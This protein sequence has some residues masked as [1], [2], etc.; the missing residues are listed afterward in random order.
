LIMKVRGVP[1]ELRRFR[2]LNARMNLSESDKSNFIYAE[3]GFEGELR[4]DKLIS[5]LVKDWVVLNDVLFEHNNTVFQIDSLFVSPDKIYPFEV[6]NFV[7]DFC[8]KNDEWFSMNGKSIKNPLHQMQRNTVLLRSLLNES[9]YRIPIESYLVFVN[10]EFHLYQAPNNK[11]IIFPNQI[12]RF[13]TSMKKERSYVGQKQI[14]LGKKILN[15]HLDK[16]PHSRIPSYTYDQLKKGIYCPQCYR[17][18]DL[19]SRNLLKCRGC[20]KR[21]HYEPAILR[22]VEEFQLLF[23]EKK[24]ATTGIHEWCGIIKTKRTVR[25]ILHKEFDLVHF[26]TMSYFKNR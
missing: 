18:Y 19:L 13:L 3:R 8:L 5:P 1:E 25:N 7:G 15:H 17:M 21:E 4:F 9:G 16:N 14:E 11:S 6:K 10:P 24:V 26:G 2:S 12:N 23:P 22:S 20:G